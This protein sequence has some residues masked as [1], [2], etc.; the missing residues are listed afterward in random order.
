MRTGLTFFVAAIALSVIIHM[1]A[2]LGVALSAGPKPFE[3]V[4]VESVTVD[5]VS[6]DEVPQPVLPERLEPGAKTAAAQAP[7][8]PVR[9][10]Q[11]STGQAPSPP[12]Q[13]APPQAAAPQAAPPRAAPP[14]ASPPQATPPQAA[15]QTAP[16]Q[17]RSPFDPAMLASMFPV[18]PV[19][20]TTESARPEGA[21]P[22]FDAPADKMAD[23]APAD[24][25]AFRAHLKKCLALPAGVAAAEKLRVVLRIALTP[26]GG[27]RGQPTLIEGTASPN[28]PALVAGVVKALRQCQPYSFLPPDKYAEWKILDLSFTPRDMEG[29]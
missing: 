17:N 26:D 3:V 24:V 13:A 18:S 12:P 6:P 2:L 14:Q 27:L 29:G 1:V 25:A 20:P 8:E 19:A 15:S 11:K 9:P 4:P 5:I 7:A 22:G 23:L 16:P 21:L 10:Q 28:G